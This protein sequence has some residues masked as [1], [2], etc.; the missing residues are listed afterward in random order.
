VNEQVQ[1]HLVP[2]QGFTGNMTTV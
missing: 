1:A 2:E